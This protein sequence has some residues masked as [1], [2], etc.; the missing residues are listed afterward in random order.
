MKKLIA[1][2]LLCSAFALMAEEINVPLKKGAVYSGKTVK[3]ESFMDEDGGNSTRVSKQL[4]STRQGNEYIDCYIRLPQAM[5]LTGKAIKFTLISENPEVIGGLYARAYNADNSKTAASSHVLWSPKPILQTQYQDIV[6]I[7]GKNGSLLKWEPK[8]VTG[9]A[10]TNVNL[11]S[12]HAGS[13]KRNVEMN[14]RIKAVKIIDSPLQQ[15]DKFFA[16]FGPF[17]SF[18][19]SGFTDNTQTAFADDVLKVYGTTPAQ[20]SRPNASMY[21][22]IRIVFSKPVDVTGKKISMEYRTVGPASGLYIRGKQFDIK[23]PCFSFLAHNRGSQEW[24]KITLD[25]NNQQTVKAKREPAYDGDLTKFQSL[26][27][28]FGTNKVSTDI[29]VEIR[30]LKLED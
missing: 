19:R 29:A 13:G 11:L 14:F 5:D 10:P 1:A 28:I 21:Q 2:L 3:I 7:P 18:E 26:S 30:N 8:A 12:I 25:L 17:C 9:A 16:N 24:T 22:G 6:V 20:A 4:T 23:K 15:A 27:I